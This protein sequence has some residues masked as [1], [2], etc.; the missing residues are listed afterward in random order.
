MLRLNFALLT[1]FHLPPSVYK[2]SS[3]HCTMALKLGLR[4]R[5]RQTICWAVFV[6]TVYTCTRLLQFLRNSNLV[7]FLY[8]FV[9]GNKSTLA[10]KSEKPEKIEKVEKEG[11][12]SSGSGS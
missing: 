5:L 1:L 12:V 4:R 2:C 8:I 9:T 10:E 11:S 6:S 7:R 3:I